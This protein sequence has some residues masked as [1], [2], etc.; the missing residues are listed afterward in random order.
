MIGQVTFT[1]PFVIV[2]AR[3]RLA[4]ITPEL[5]EAA[6][7]LGASPSATMWLVLVR[8]LHARDRRAR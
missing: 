8:L 4:S 2:I 1:M 7:D 6:M 3:A 5:E